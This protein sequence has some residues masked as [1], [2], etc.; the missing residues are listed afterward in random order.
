[1][2]S[3]SGCRYDGGPGR[4]HDLGQGGDVVG[5][6]VGLEDRAERVAAGLELAEQLLG[7]CSG[8]HEERVVA[9]LVEREPG[10]RLIRPDR[11]ASY[12]QHEWRDGI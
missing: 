12:R 1:M 6:G 9:R 5:V 8:V 4:G 10:V 3:A 7:L 11:V 2:G